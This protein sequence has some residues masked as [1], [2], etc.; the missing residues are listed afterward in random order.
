MVDIELSFRNLGDTPTDALAKGYEIRW[1]P[2]ITA[3]REVVNPKH[4]GAVG[5]LLGTG[6]L[7][8]VTKIRD[9]DWTTPG[10][11]QEGTDA[12]EVENK[13]TSWAAMHSKY[14]VAALLAGGLSDPQDVQRRVR[15]SEYEAFPLPWPPE[16]NRYRLLLQVGKEWLLDEEHFNQERTA[17]FLFLPAGKKRINQDIA[18]AV[19]GLEDTPKDRRKLYERTQQIY[20]EYGNVVSLLTGTRLEVSGFFLEP[21]EVLTDRFRLYAGPKH[22]QLLDNVLLPDGKRAHLESLIEFGLTGPLAKGL[23]WL[24]KLFYGVVHNY[25]VAIVLL[26]ILIRLALF[27][28]A[29]RS[30][31]TMKRMQTRMRI[32]QPEIEA[33][34]KKYRDDPQRMNAE[35]MKV[36]RKYGVNPASQ[37]GGCLMILVQ[38]PILFAMFTMLRNAAELRGE[39]FVLWIHDLTAPDLLVSVGGFPIRLLPLI[40]TGGTILQQMLSPMTG[41]VSGGQKT[42]MYLMPI[43]FLFFFYGMA[44]GLNL[45]WG[46]STLIGVGQQYLVNRYSSDEEEH[47]TA[48]DLERMARQA[49]KKRRERAQLPRF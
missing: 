3:D 41:S 42:M 6:Q 43:L 48:A 9:E 31:K 37:L 32:I 35:M 25:G 34:R 21:G 10:P 24:L 39:P 13:R 36:Y 5:G 49:R 11:Q 16:P 45:Y 40:V 29:Q 38:M 14:F 27:P 22:T 15:F 47:L 44:S 30:S 23:L 20:A 26:T 8:T 17:R 28:I 19:S 33:V 4:A 2:G 12:D 7:V 18:Q 46:M 1:G